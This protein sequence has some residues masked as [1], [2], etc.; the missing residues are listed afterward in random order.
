M[1]QRLIE[2]LELFEREKIEI[3]TA[4]TEVVVKELV[5]EYEAKVR[6]ELEEK[7]VKSLEA[8]DVEIN[9]LKRIIEIEQRKQEE[10]A[11]A[12][13]LAFLHSFVL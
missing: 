11:Q 6:K 1:V 9:A 5:A 8:K 7:R 3:E 4:D 10:E 12:R 2:H 13:F